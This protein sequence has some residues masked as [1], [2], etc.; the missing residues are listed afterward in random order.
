MMKHKPG[1]PPKG[2][3]QPRDFR[4]HSLPKPEDIPEGFKY[5]EG[6]TGWLKLVPHELN[7]EKFRIGDSGT[8]NSG[9]YCLM[10]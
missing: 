8:Q 7:K 6:M 1:E 10:R 3:F 9:T 2:A 4:M 5:K